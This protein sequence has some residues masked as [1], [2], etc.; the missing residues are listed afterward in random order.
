MQS[1]L[2]EFLRQDDDL[3]PRDPIDITPAPAR[4]K[5]VD[6]VWKG[7]IFTGESTT[8][9][10]NEA[11]YLNFF[12]EAMSIAAETGG[13]DGLDAFWDANSAGLQAVEA[14]GFEAGVAEI[15]DKRTELDAGCRPPAATKPENTAETSTRESAEGGPEAVKDGGAADGPHAGEDGSTQEASEKGAPG[16]LETPAVPKSTSPASWATWR[17]GV[18]A[19][20]ASTASE[21]AIGDFLEGG[22]MAKAPDD[23]AGEIRAAGHQRLDEIVNA[24]E[25]AGAG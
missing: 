18:I 17:K 24:R 9:F 7:T 10:D 8:T 11:E 14:R 3:E 13:R 15:R 20:F 16:P 4:P 6:Y 2:D 23:I 5:R 25:L 21:S 19:A 12:S 1:D 22:D